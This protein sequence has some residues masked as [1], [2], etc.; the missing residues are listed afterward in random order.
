M[1]GYCNNA[2][3]G[4]ILQFIIREDIID[5]NELSNRFPKIALYPCPL[6]AFEF[7]FYLC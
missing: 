7:I 6:F 5:Y 1:R 4:F 3:D 2:G